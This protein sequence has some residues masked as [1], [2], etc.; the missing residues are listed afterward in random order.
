MVG[1]PAVGGEAE[2]RDAADALGLAVAELPYQHRRIFVGQPF[3]N[4][5]ARVRELREHVREDAL[6]GGD[7]AHLVER[8]FEPDVLGIELREARQGFGREFLV[9]ADQGVEVHVSLR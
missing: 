5:E 7:A 1:D 3:G 8:V 9:V 4:D 2:V 6:D